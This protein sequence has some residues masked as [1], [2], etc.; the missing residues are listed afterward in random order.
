[1]MFHFLNRER[2]LARTSSPGIQ[3]N[4]LSG[5]PYQLEEALEPHAICPQ[6]NPGARVILF[7]FP[8]KQ[9][10]SVVD[11][12]LTWLLLALFALSQRHGLAGLHVGAFEEHQADEG[13]WG[14]RGADGDTHEVQQGQEWE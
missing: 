5:L 4:D 7:C 6:M 1:M 9:V 10:G 2:N 3:A 13:E 8:Y 11:V 14:A 12:S